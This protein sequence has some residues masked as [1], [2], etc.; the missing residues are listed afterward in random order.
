MVGGFCGMILLSAK[1][2][3]SFGRRHWIGGQGR[4]WTPLHARRLNAK[5]VLKPQRSGNTIDGSV[6]IFGRELRLWT[7]TLTRDRPERGEK[8]EIFQGKSDELHSPTQLQGDSTRDDEEAKSD[9]WL[10]KR[11]DLSSSCGTPEST[12]TCRGKNHFL[13]CWST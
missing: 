7:S 5:E 11:I 1:H 2:S 8:Q 4:I 3:R 13:P 6:K 9:F 12:C 10:H